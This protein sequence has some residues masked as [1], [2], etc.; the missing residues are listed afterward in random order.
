MHKKP[1][2]QKT[3]A[4]FQHHHGER[5]NMEVQSMKNQIRSEKKGSNKAASP[6]GKS[7]SESLPDISEKCSDYFQPAPSRFFGKA[8]PVLDPDLARRVKVLSNEE[9]IRLACIYERWAVQLR[10]V[11][12]HQQQLN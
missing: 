11:V 4:V 12:F 3:V 7:Q 10:G 1:Y 2:K 9:R 6:Q 5:P 8:P